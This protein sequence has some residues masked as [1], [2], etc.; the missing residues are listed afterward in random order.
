MFLISFFQ[1]AT[2]FEDDGGKGGPKNRII[3]W[4]NSKINPWGK[5]I[6][7]L[8]NDWNNGKNI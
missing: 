1:I 2:G 5:S 6:T 3:K 7:N 8:N 4:V